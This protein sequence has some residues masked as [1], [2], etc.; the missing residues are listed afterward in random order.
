MRTIAIT[1]PENGPRAGRVNRR[2]LVPVASQ[3]VCRSLHHDVEIVTGVHDRVHRLV[4]VETL[5]LLG[6]KGETDALILQR[7]H[8][9]T[10]DY[11]MPRRSM[12]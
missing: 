9:V 10:G 4:G 1:P 5:A 3:R 6:L 7:T 2:N 11:L 8:R 12:R